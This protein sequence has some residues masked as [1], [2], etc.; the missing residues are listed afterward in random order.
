MRIHRYYRFELSLLQALKQVIGQLLVLTNR[1]I[2]ELKA[3][4]INEYG[5]SLKLLK[6]L[7]LDLNHCI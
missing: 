2:S 3:I 7:L 6:F 1:R 5:F 4:R